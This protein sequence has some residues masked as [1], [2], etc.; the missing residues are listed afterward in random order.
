MA[1]TVKDLTNVI[2]NLAAETGTPFGLDQA[3]GGVRLT[4]ESGGRELTPRVTKGQLYDIVWSAL[5]IIR[6]AK[7]EGGAMPF[8]SNRRRG[9]R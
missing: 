4:D 7:R 5:N 6:Y 2:R 3:Y 9:A 1:T 8:A